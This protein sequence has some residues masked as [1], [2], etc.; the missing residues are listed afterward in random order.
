MA[1]R[2]LLMSLST[3]ET[4]TWVKKDERMLEAM[5]EGKQPGIRECNLCIIPGA[6]C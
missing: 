1:A 3:L 5:K 4:T 2:E 6:T